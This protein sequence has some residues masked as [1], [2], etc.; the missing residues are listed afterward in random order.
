M[1]GTF[2]NIFKIPDLRNKILFTIALLVIYRI[3]YH[4]PVP[5]FDQEQITK[6]AASRDKETPLGRAAETLQMFTGG[7]LSHSSLFG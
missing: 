3:G 5:G 2:A 6:Q 4:I 1:L 7:T